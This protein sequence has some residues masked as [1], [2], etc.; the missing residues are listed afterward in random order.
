MTLMF[1]Y[2]Q[3]TGARTQSLSHVVT[4]SPRPFI[5]ISGELDPSLFKNVGV[6]PD[7]HV[8]RMSVIRSLLQA[9]EDVED[10]N[11]TLSLYLDQIEYFEN[12]GRDRTP[13]SDSADETIL[14]QLGEI[15]D[16]GPF[17]LECLKIMDIIEL[18]IGRKTVRLYGNHEIMS[19]LSLRIT[20]QVTCH[21]R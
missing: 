10:E 21:E 11:L 14:V 9:F 1:H 15:V 2:H 4:T 3:P 6:I 18:A 5:D 16:R 12:G 19:D 20:S 17:G 7:I 13:L 8:D